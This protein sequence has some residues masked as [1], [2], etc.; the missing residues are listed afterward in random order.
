MAG[1]GEPPEAKRPKVLWALCK[2]GHAAIH[3]F[4][5]EAVALLW[6]PP[7]PP[8]DFWSG[9]GGRMKQSLAA[10]TASWEQTTLS[11]GEASRQATY[12]G[13]DSWW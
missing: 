8:A 1:R 4:L 6:W 9:R 3:I 2:G 7:W 5:T 13:P 10:R 12:E 11:D